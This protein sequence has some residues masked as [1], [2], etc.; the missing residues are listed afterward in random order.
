[1]PAS[2]AAPA[3]KTFSASAVVVGGKSFAS[4]GVV[5]VQYRITNTST[6][7]QTFASANVDVPFAAS[8]CDLTSPCT[9]PGD[10]STTSS[11]SN[12]F[13]WTLSG[14]QAQLRSTGTGGIA[15]GG[16][17]TMDIWVSPASACATALAAWSTA[18]KQS[19]DFSGTGNDFAGT[20]A[21]PAGALVWTRQPPA[22]VQTKEAIA[23]API[24]TATDACGASTPAVI[25]VVDQAGVLS[26][27]ATSPAT[28]SALTFSTFDFYDTLVASADGF[29]SVSSS[30]FYVAEVMSTCTS[31]ACGPLGV[32][33]QHTAAQI[34]L[35]PPTSGSALASASHTAPLSG[36]TCAGKSVPD[37][38]VSDTITVNT[39]GDGGKTVVITLDKALVNAISNN[40]TPF[41][42][43]CFQ[44]VSA[45]TPDPT[46]RPLPD[47]TATP[48]APC[49][50][51]RKKNSANEIVTVALPP[52]DPRLNLY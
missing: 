15:P 50:V 13:S 49:V 45:G 47:C 16:S 4:T 46:S 6:S 37:G 34:S 5:Q 27:S 10:L 2:N 23:P 29:P 9:T 32:T 12:T 21:A 30:S 41:M 52:G 43:V 48:T 8:T 36:F 28:F 22:F 7:P 44:G 20:G 1:M 38:T 40:G 31:T 35:V 42:S 33:G 25:T 51:S 24:V 17:V 26:A 19:N 11:S 3:K 14:N 18:V 39:I